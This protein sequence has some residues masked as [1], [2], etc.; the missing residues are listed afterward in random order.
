[1]V[2]GTKFHRG[3]LKAGL[4]R[5]SKSNGNRKSKILH[6]GKSQNPSPVEVSLDNADTVI[7]GA[8]SLR[9]LQGRERRTWARSQLQYSG[10]R[11]R[12]MKSGQSLMA[13]TDV[14]S[15]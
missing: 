15:E 2:G 10:R 14:K 4:G 1:M 3:I 13:R 6:E 12:K 11:G 9:F 5:M 7:E 8:P